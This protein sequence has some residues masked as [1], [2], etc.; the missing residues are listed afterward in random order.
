MSSDKT[1]R[2]DLLVVG[3]GLAA[4]QK[5][6]Q[7]L[8]MAGE[9][10]VEDCPITKSGTKVPI[11][12]NI[13]LRTVRS[14][15]VGRGGDKIDP[16]FDAFCVNLEDRVTIDVGASTG[17]FT[18][19]MLQRG[20]R[21]VYAVDVGTAQLAEKLRQDKRV[22]VY[23]KT[24]AKQLPELLFPEPPTLA[25]IDVSFTSLV[26]VLEPV[27]MV[28][29]GEQ[30]ILCLVKPQFELDAS[31]VEDGG[32]VR[33]LE[34]HRKAIRKVKDFAKEIG[35]DTVAELPA[36]TKGNKKGNQEYF[37]HLKPVR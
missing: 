37:L 31:E 14:R 5:L 10:L 24:H 21:L 8:I 13:R 25:T 16:L 11:A 15:F 2:L 19:A 29:Q 1:I 36:A 12:S 26:R 30:E 4:T 7:S 23:E 9:I 35:L 33:D 34:L 32:L 17:G 27:K 18:D 28:L 3:Q 22:H 6:A 20:A